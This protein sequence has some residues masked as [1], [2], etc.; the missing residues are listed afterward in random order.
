MRALSNEAFRSALSNEAFMRAMSNEAFVKAMDN[1]AFRSALSNEAFVRALDNEAFRRPSPTR[2]SCGRC[3][4]KPVRPSR[5][6]R[7]GDREAP[8]RRL[9][10][11]IYRMQPRA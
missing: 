3:R 4:T 1:E 2:R 11:R 7:P 5:T 6:C 10:V 8:R 9:P